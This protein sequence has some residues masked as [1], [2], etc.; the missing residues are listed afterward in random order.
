MVE[1]PIEAFFSLSTA[2]CPKV[3][4]DNRWVAA[5]RSQGR[6]YKLCVYDLETDERRELINELTLSDPQ[7]LFHR[8]AADS[9]A[10]YYQGPYKDGSTPVYQATLDG[11]VVRLF[12][13]DDE[14]RLWAVN[15]QTEALYYRV[16]EGILRW[17][18]PVTEEHAEFP[19]YP[20]LR[21]GIQAVCTVSPDGEW[22]AYTARPSGTEPNVPTP[23]VSGF[24]TYISRADGQE[25]RQIELPSD[26]QKLTPVQWHP[27]GERLLV[28]T[29]PTDYHER[30]CGLYDRT[31]REITW[32][33]DNG[34][35]GFLE[36]GEKVLGPD[37]PFTHKEIYDLDGTTTTLDCEGH[38]YFCRGNEAIVGGHGFV[39]QKNVIGLSKEI[40]YYDIESEKSTVLFAIQR[41]ERTL[42]EEDFIEPEE[43][44]YTG[45]DGES[46]NGLLYQS[47][48][49]KITPAVAIVYGGR[50]YSEGSRRAN[51]KAQVLAHRGYSVL[52]P[53][54]PAFG[55]HEEHSYI[56]AAGKWLG[57]HP[58][59]DG[60]RIAVYGHSHGGYN[61][62]IQAVRYPEVWD[63]FV[64]DTGFT[65]IYDNYTGDIREAIG[66]PNQH[67]EIY[68]DLSPINHVTQNT[69][70]PLLMIYGEDDR[71][72]EQVRLFTSK[73]EELGWEAGNE[74]TEEVLENVGHTVKEYQKQVEKWD[75]IIGFLDRHLVD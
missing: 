15:P 40:Q 69:G 44:Q 57:D 42:E 62:Y 37:T 47:P 3:S 6:Q 4:P 19:D 74:Y 39:L 70:S 54:C 61:V 67:E 10:L 26:V 8:W 36:D 71:A 41:G 53:D 58:S 18:D 17:Y 43:C 38:C 65:D 45:P 33:T 28:Q 21:I 52:L 64:A 35:I 63:A 1:Q 60:N 50:S 56:A 48:S 46:I 16:G 20:G 14:I 12:T 59:I 23:H 72:A 29:D 13:V 49:G 11:E 2:W 75:K 73:L 5:V 66:D 32:I 30:R 31:D 68:K 51:E 7:D 34:A 24:T 55:S 9:S 22:V 25:A 27:D